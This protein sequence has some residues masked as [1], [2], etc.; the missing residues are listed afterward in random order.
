MPNDLDKI[1]VTSDVKICV[2]Q[3]NFSIMGVTECSA[4]LSPGSP[5]CSWPHV[6]DG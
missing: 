6:T 1:N 2:R 5:T 4:E 3:S